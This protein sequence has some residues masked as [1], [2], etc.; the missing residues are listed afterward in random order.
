MRRLVII[1]AFEFLQLTIIEIQSDI[2]IEDYGFDRRMISAMQKYSLGAVSGRHVHNYSLI[3]NSSSWLRYPIKKIGY[4]YFK[5][6]E[7]I[8]LVGNKI[9]SRSRD[10]DYQKCYIG[11]TVARGPWLLNKADLQVLGY[12]DQKNFFL[13]N[14]DHDYHL[15]LG[16]S[17]SKAV[18]YCPVNIYSV[19]EEGASRKKRSGTNL[20]IYDYLKK[21][22]T[23]S[24]EFK[25]FLRSYSPYREIITCDNYY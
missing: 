1:L 20:E 4:K 10:L 8:G 15:R 17:L 9:F 13:G 14:D 25:K 18:G 3:D 21:V 24:L 5:K 19:P 23:G 6:R 2:Y 11:E 12:L 16:K 22:K 7:S